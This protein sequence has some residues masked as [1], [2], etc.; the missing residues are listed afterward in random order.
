[1]FI[2]FQNILDF[3]ITKTI[4]FIAPIPAIIKWVACLIM[5]NAVVIVT[6]ELSNQAS[7][8]YYRKLTKWNW[9]KNR[10]VQ[11]LICHNIESIFVIPTHLSSSSLLSPQSSLPSHF[12]DWSTQFP[13]W[14]V[15]LAVGQPNP[16]AK[17]L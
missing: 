16:P 6:S 10:S 17:N 12:C 8:C 4:C 15:N 1:M 5:S 3:H 9:W 7:I 11:I 13:F 14:H 2:C